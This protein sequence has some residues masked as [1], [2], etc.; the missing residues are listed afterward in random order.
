MS[1]LCPLIKVADSIQS[2][3]WWKEEKED[4]ITNSPTEM[5]THTNA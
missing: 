2:S 3:F 5:Q 4:S 1:I